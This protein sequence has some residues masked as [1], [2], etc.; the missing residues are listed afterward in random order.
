MVS[1]KIFSPLKTGE[2]ENEHSGGGEFEDEEGKMN[3]IEEQDDD[4][5]ENKEEGEE[6]KKPEEKAPEE[7]LDTFFLEM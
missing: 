6:G 7:V 4:R 3:D 2:E 1:V 5:D